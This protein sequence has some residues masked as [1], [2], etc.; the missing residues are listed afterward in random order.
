LIERKKER[1]EG[2]KEEREGGRKEWRK[3][4]RNLKKRRSNTFLNAF[5]GQKHL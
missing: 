1:K 4:G 2:R 3:E 5:T